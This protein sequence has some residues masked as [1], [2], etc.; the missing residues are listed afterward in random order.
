MPIARWRRSCPSC[1]NQG[2]LAA[3]EIGHDQAEAG[4]GLLAR[5]GLQ[6]RLAHDFADRPRALLLTWATTK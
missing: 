6:A 1:C 4:Y 3:V 2:G 5:D